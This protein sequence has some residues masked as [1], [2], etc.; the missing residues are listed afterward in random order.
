MPIIYLYAA[1]MPCCA[2]SRC[3]TDRASGLAEDY[4]LQKFHQ[5]RVQG[6]I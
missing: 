1:V 5:E 6:I 2:R 4:S 3:L